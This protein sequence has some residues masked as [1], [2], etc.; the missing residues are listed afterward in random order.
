M[1]KPYR[2]L[3]AQMSPAAQQQALAKAEAHLTAEEWQAITAR[4]WA[5]QAPSSR[6]L[7]VSTAPA[8]MPNKP[9]TQQT[10][11]CTDVADSP[12]AGEG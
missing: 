10:E 6:W 12:R 9:L 11:R 7:E 3:R 2:Q 8:A 1:A 4:V 5:R